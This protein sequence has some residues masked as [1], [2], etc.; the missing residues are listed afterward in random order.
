M[1]IPNSSYPNGLSFSEKE[2][3]QTPSTPD[4]EFEITQNNLAHFPK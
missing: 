3:S 1:P 2:A 4:E